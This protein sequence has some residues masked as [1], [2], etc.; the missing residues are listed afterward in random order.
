MP[1]PKNRKVR[2]NATPTTLALRAANDVLAARHAGTTVHRA[3]L[4][5]ARQMADEFALPIRRSL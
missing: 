5:D 4:S 1:L 2:N 3:M